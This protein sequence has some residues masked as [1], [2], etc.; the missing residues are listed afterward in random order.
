MALILSPA[1]SSATPRLNRTSPCSRKF[2]KSREIV[3]AVSKY[4]IGAAALQVRSRLFR[5]RQALRLRLYNSQSF[6]RWLAPVH[7]VDGLLEVPKRG[8][9][10]CEVAG[11]G[12]FRE[13][14]SDLTCKIKSLLLEFQ[15]VPRMTKLRCSSPNCPIA[16]FSPFRS[17]VSCG[18]SS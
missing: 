12:A 8:L 9:G 7:T 17:P 11:I 16:W 14:V 4:S 15:G 1:L 18:I 5:G 3:S 2:S 10:I 13:S 6:F